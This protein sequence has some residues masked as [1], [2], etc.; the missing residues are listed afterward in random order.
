MG[1]SGID[2]LASFIDLLAVHQHVA[3]K[4]QGPGLFT[5]F[6]ELPVDEH[7]IE[8]LPLHAWRRTI[9]SASSRRRSARSSNAFS[10]AC[11]QI[12]SSSAIARER[13]NP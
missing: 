12:R 8:A 13:S 9:R 2:A 6:D 7:L 5:G 1:D 11:A 10:A 3:G 4:D